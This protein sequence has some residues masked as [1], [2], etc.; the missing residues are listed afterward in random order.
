MK[1]Y[2]GII[3]QARLGSSRFPGKIRE[4]IYGKP[5]LEHIINQC[6]ESKLARDVIIASPENPMLCLDERLFIGSE[7]DVLDRYYQCAKHCG[8][9]IIVRIT[10]DCP[11]IHPIEIDR[12]IQYLIDHNL[13]YT[14]NR[15]G[16]PDGFDVEV[17]T[18]CTL[19]K[20]W[21]EAKEPYDREHVTS[22]IKSNGFKKHEL[23]PLKLSVDTKEDLERV[24]Q[25]IGQARLY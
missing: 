15:P 3:I 14:T 20:A 19:E 25:W 24:K 21:Q 17:F 22:Y 1:P 5:M 4:S 7:D 9:D 6:H 23:E 12:C 2:I 10:A 13:D 18:F 8:F 16:M 11:L